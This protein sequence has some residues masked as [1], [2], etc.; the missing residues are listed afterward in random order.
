MPSLEMGPRDKR[1]KREDDTIEDA[2]THSAWHTRVTGRLRQAESGSRANKESQVCD[3]G[4]LRRESTSLY[5]APS[6]T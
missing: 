2:R 4:P 5:N 3:Q 6:H 1:D